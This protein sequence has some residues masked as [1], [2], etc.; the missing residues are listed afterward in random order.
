MDKQSLRCEF[1]KRRDQKSEQARK[2]A[3]EQIYKKLIHSSWYAQAGIIFSY[4]SF[5]SE[6]DTER[7]HQKIWKDGK[8]LLL[9]RVDQ[10]RKEM[11]FYVVR[12]END[13]SPGYLGILEPMN[14]DL[15][16]PRK[17]ER[18]LMLL[19]GAVFDDAK[20]RIGYGGGFYDRY[21]NCYGEWIDHKIMLAFSS[22]KAEYI[23]VEHTDQ[24]VEEIITD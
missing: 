2:K 20:S 11:D 10:K 21:L 13:L 4:A 19:P 7:I 6:V 15:W 3:S 9:P 23:P 24:P 8:T 22:Q 16:T 17:E 5:R 18:T 14:T 12:S 1:L